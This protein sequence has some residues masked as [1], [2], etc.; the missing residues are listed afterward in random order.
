MPPIVGF[1]LTA[2]ATQNK[3]SPLLWG[4]VSMPTIHLQTLLIK[5]Q[6]PKSL[7]MR[8]VRARTWRVPRLVLR[9]QTRAASRSIGPKKFVR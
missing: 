8:R 2:G 4:L 3:P 5:R 6:A 1:M 9:S 7:P